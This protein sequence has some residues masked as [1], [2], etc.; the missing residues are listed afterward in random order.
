MAQIAV[1]TRCLRDAY[2]AVL[3]V[4]IG[5]PSLWN[6]TMG[7]YGYELHRKARC[8]I[9]SSASRTCSIRDLPALRDVDILISR[10]PSSSDHVRASRSIDGNTRSE[11]ANVVADDDGVLG[12]RMAGDPEVVGADWRPLR[13]ERP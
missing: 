7:A 10:A 13:S 3:Y 4:K 11:F 12:Q 2:A 1:S 6:L 5:S 8:T 9:H